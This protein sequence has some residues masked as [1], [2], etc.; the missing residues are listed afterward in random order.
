MGGIS[1]ISRIP[2]SKYH[3]NNIDGVDYDSSDRWALDGQ[4]L[5]L[6]SG[7]YGTNGA[8]YETENY[9]NLKIVSIG[10][11]Y[12]GAGYGPSYF[13]VYY[14]DGSK[15]YYG[16][17]G[18]SKTSTTYGITSWEDHKSI[19]IDYSYN[20][21]YQS[22]YISKIKYGGMGSS[23]TSSV[24]NEI[25]FIYGNQARPQ[26]AFVGNYSFVKNKVLRGIESYSNNI[27]Y[28]GYSLSHSNESEYE[29]LNS[30]LERSGDGSQTH[31]SIY[32]NYNNPSPSNISYQG[33]TTTGLNNL[34][35]RN[36]KAVSLDI[37]GNGNLDYIVYPNVKNKFWLF[38]D[39]QNGNYTYPYEVNT[40]N[41]KSLFPVTALNHQGKILAGQNIG[42][43]QDGSNNTVN[44]KVYS[45]GT[46]SPIYYQYTK[47]WNQPTYSYYS[48][49]NNSSQ[50]RIPFEYVSGDFNGDGLTE[51]LAI[52]KPYTSRYCYY[53]G[54]CDDPDPCDDVPF[55]KSTDNSNLSRPDPCLLK[56][57]KKSGQIK[58]S[59]K[60]DD[61]YLKGKT[62]TSIS[63]KLEVGAPFKVESSRINN[64]GYS[65][66]SSTSNYR[67]VYKIDLKRDLNSGYAQYSGYLQKHLSGNY[68]I[69]PGDFNGDGKTDIMHI[70]EEKIAYVYSFN[71]SGQM[72]LL[73]STNLLSTYNPDPNWPFLLGDYNGD[74]KTDFMH[75]TGNNSNN[76]KLGLSTGTR[77]YM[78]I[79]SMPFPFQTSTWNGTE[80]NTYNYIPLDVNGDGKTDIVRHH[81]KTY[82]NSSNGTQS[83]KSYH[84]EGLKALN[85]P[86]SMLFYMRRNKTFSGN[87][88]HYPIPMFLSSDDGNKGIELATLSHNWIKKFSFNVDFNNML[89]NRISNNGVVHE[90]DYKN[91]DPSNYNEDGMQIYNSGYDQLYPNV[92]IRLSPNIRVAS[93]FKRVVSGSPHL[94]QLFAYQGGVYN[95]EGLSFLGFQG[96]TRSNWH[97]GN[98]DRVFKTSKYDIDLRGTLEA[99]YSQTYSFNFNIP[100]SNYILKTTY[101]NGH[102]LSNTKV[103]KS[104]VNSKLV[105]NTLQ[106]IEINSAYQYDNYN[107]PTNISTNYSGDGS[108]NVAYTYANSTGSTYYIGR[109]T[110]RVETSTIGGNNI[111]SEQQFVYS[112]YLLTQIKSKGDD[113][114]FNSVAFEYDSFGNV[115]K[116]ITTPSGEPSRI[117][118][119]E[120]DST[121][122][123][124]KKHTDLEGLV[125]NYQYN[126]NI[127]TLTST[128]NAFG[129]TTSYEY[130]SWFR[131]TKATDY[132]GKKATTS[133][134]E[135]SNQYTV[136]SNGDDGSSM[137]SKFDRLQR[138]SESHQK[139]VLGQ[140]TKVKYEYDALGRNS[141]VSQPYTGTNP[142][143]WDETIYDF[144]GRPIEQILYTGRVFS[145]DYNGLTTTV[146]DGTKTVSS[147]TNA[148]GNIITANDPGGTIYYTYHG[149][150]S[151]KTANYGGIVVSTEIDGWG[152]KTKLTD[153]SAGIYEYEY[154]GYGELTKE[155]NPKGTTEYKYSSIGKL[156]QKR[157]Q[158]D[159]TDMTISYTYHPAY[160]SPT[161]ISM[162][163]AD[164][165]NSSYVYTYD[166]Q[167]RLTSIT[168]N[169]PH[170]QFKKDYTY[171]SF[172]RVNTENYYAK[173][174][175]NGKTSQKKITNIYQNGGLKQINEAKF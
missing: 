12:H 32:F 39:V 171:D 106:G 123:F 51:V 141:R 134:V 48:S 72:Q 137:V 43:V 124:M 35:Q 163:S 84:S 15:A 80:L 26:Q 52:G 55:E 46:T 63:E 29:R 135:S 172:G 34:D 41:F 126:N 157:I 28:R 156:Q 95:V 4:R 94:K 112:G 138:L 83:I 59:Q 116:Q 169:N 107:N 76:F 102:S 69:L 18:S 142:S 149:N 128:T 56:F 68:K 42:I 115:K 144:Y 31:T 168:E 92:D 145:I 21:S 8:I 119:Y 130:D 91:L 24:M 11:W 120:Y 121:G 160:K 155:I 87:L 131:Q 5:I 17:G 117:L 33:L 164:G 1:S 148:M 125:S 82:N 136:T 93:M 173:L 79:K 96:V 109:A 165:N 86:L 88:K 20:L 65:C 13:I 146:N 78:G 111:S 45:N 152:Q 129:Q 153:P 67:S 161:N 133:Y 74:G 37:S 143:Q 9:S 77:F 53:H 81:A 44:F 89:I 159:K 147:T 97:T 150:G 64:C 38:K 60:V 105:K 113:T 132:L 100:S 85:D 170:A 151:L 14:P 25:R 61:V 75:A 66:Y 23:N 154:N 47:V 10:S 73:W 174:L 36:A 50:K 57:Q 3:D 139:D 98:S 30:I 2:S 127:G 40:G 114:A 62:T 108:N 27:R 19:R 99:E 162:T 22:L 167:I 166:S 90:I 7:T 16:N 140:W 110:K 49:P 58:E 71:N 6:K 122:R 104:W 118:Q 101:Q 103:F 54:D 70:T 158:G 175:S